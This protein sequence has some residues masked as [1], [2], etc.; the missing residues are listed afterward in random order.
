MSIK[1]KGIN[2]FIGGIKNSQINIQLF[3]TFS[4]LEENNWMRT[5]I[6]K[7]EKFNFFVISVL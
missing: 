5:V 3:P 4:I 1:L 2:Q 7:D 6:S